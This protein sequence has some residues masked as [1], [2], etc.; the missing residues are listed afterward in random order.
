M[1]IVAKP[2]PPKL[3]RRSRLWAWTQAIGFTL[4]IPAGAIVM[5]V[6]GWLMFKNQE[7]FQDAFE[8]FV[9]LAI[10]ALA[11]DRSTYRAQLKLALLER[12]QARAQLA[13]KQPVSKQV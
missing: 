8:A 9:A 13:Q 7:A 1:K 6:I 3:T 4:L 5:G 2:V 11:V 12:D 10:L